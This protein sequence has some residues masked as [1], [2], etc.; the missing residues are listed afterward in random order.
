MVQLI[1]IFDDQTGFSEA[2]SFEPISK[3]QAIE[4]FNKFS[5]WPFFVQAIFKPL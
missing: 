5:T 1:I 2:L 4:L 3:Q